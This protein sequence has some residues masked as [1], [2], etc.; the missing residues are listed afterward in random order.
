MAQSS[1]NMLEAFK[2]SGS[3]E[4]VPD[5]TRPKSKDPSPPA[6][7]GGPFA[8]EPPPRGEPTPAIEEGLHSLAATQR[9][10]IAVF[11]VALVF[12]LGIGWV[13]GSPREVI[14]TETVTAPPIDLPE[15]DAS[16]PATSRAQPTP[17][18][19]RAEPAANAPVEAIMDPQ[20][21]FSIMV[22]AYGLGKQDLAS[23][24]VTHLEDQGF[25]A[26][27]V[28]KGQSIYVLA[29]AAPESGD[30]DDRTDAL[31]KIS[32]PN[33]KARAFDDAYVVRISNYLAR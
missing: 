11:G 27:M 28:Q 32:G 18:P 6:S 31:R 14:A 21:E 17:E 3:T 20:N 24:T 9:M 29:C 1:K 15:I 4:P 7:A 25:P 33:G 19:A 2:A 8:N 22:V 13:L 12:A 23:E 10:R 5:G 16:E 26:W 30:L